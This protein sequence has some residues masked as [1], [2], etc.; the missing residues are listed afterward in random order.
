MNSESLPRRE[1]PT[2]L[3]VPI[4]DAQV[5]PLGQ[6]PLAEGRAVIGRKSHADQPA[7]CFTDVG[8]EVQ[9]RASDERGGAHAHE[10]EERRAQR[11][12]SISAVVGEFRGEI[13]EGTVVLAVATRVDCD[14]PIRE[15][16]RPS[17]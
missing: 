11:D 17:P 4:H 12:L 10:S 16:S 9:D 6:V 13:L 1:K 7:P 3:G 14:R 2:S 5:C 15:L 8:G